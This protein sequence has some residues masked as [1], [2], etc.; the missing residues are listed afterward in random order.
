MKDTFPPKPGDTHERLSDVEEMLLTGAEPAQIHRVALKKD[1]GLTP[2]ELDAIITQAAERI[3]ESPPPNAPEETRTAFRRLARLFGRSYAVQ[4]YKTALAAQKEIN[5]LLASSPEPVDEKV[6]ARK[7]QQEWRAWKFIGNTTTIERKRRVLV[8]FEDHGAAYPACR[9]AGVPRSEYDAW[10]NDDDEYLRAVSQVVEY[11]IQRAESDMY[12]D[13]SFYDRAGKR[14]T[15]ARFGFL[16]AKADE[17]GLMKRQLLEKALAKTLDEAAKIVEQH[18]SPEA[19][20]EIR[21]SFDAL[22]DRAS[23]LPVG[24]SVK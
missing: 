11:C 20:H 5:R 10:C 19:A 9:A 2:T 1:W 12:R 8:A 3:S 22:L 4:D 24:A 17:W 18:L 7:R 23:R 21:A 16:N 14:N 6:E 13:G 15:S